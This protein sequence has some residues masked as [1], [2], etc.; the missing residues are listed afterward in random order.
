MVLLKLTT[1]K[2]CVVLFPV[3]SDILMLHS[4]SK[5]MS[6]QMI[7][8]DWLDSMYIME[9]HINTSFGLFDLYFDTNGSDSIAD[10]LIFNSPMHTDSVIGVFLT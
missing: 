3:D 2:L 9:K 8:I 1:R 6:E 4:Y 10:S 5:D 7:H